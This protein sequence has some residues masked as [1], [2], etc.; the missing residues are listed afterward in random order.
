MYIVLLLQ[1]LREIEGALEREER[2]VLRKM[3]A[4]A[5]QYAV[6]LQR[7]TPEQMRRDSRFH[8]QN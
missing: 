1:K 6:D 4:E 5:Q 8:F 2:A 7:E 3:V